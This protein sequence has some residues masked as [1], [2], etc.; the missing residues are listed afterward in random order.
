VNW[1]TLTVLIDLVRAHIETGRL[2]LFING[3]IWRRCSSQDLIGGLLMHLRRFLPIFMSRA[4]VNLMFVW[5]ITD[6]MPLRLNVT[7]RVV[8]WEISGN[9]LRNFSGNFRKNNGTFTGKIPRK[10]SDNLWYKSVMKRS[11]KCPQYHLI[12]YVRLK[13]SSITEK[14]IM[15]NG[16]EVWTWPGWMMNWW[17]FDSWISVFR[18]FTCLLTLCSQHYALYRPTGKIPE[19][20]MHSVSPEKLQP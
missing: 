15:V 5:R 14:V 7:F 10:F 19:N 2:Y 9:F 13:N 6:K 12:G 18:C 11:K 3:I 1:P 17:W 8:S 4:L 16:P 20:F